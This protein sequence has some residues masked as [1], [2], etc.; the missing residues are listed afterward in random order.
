MRFFSAQ[1]MPLPKESFFWVKNP[2]Q[3]M[4]EKIWKNFN[5]DSRIGYFLEVFI[6][7]KLFRPYLTFRL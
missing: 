6:G 4:S 7:C 1:S 5:H 3:F 2:E